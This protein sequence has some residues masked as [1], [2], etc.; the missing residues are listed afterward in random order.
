MVKAVRRRVAETFKGIRPNLF[1]DEPALPPKNTSADKGGNSTE[2]HNR[3]RPELVDHLANM[4]SFFR[5]WIPQIK[6]DLELSALVMNGLADDLGSSVHDIATRAAAELRRLPVKYS[7]LREKLTQEYVG[8]AADNHHEMHKKRVIQ[9]ECGKQ[10]TLEQF[11]EIFDHDHNLALTEEPFW[12]NEFREEF[13][14]G[15]PVFANQMRLSDPACGSRKW[16][17]PPAEKDEL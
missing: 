17:L 7:R 2:L 10:Y 6:K 14:Q 15:W 8:T 5:K 13:F 12:T 9:S 3:P 16:S 1:L 4:D 11:I